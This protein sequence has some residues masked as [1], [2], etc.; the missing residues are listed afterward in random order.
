MTA[1]TNYASGPEDVVFDVGRKN[2][3]VQKLLRD[4]YFLID[5]VEN[6]ESVGLTLMPRPVGT[7]QHLDKDE[8][9]L[10]PVT[11][12]VLDKWVETDYKSTEIVENVV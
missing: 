4:S 11:L 1:G 7:S 8:T 6:D 5:I 2:N 3:E 9:F 10:A 12:A